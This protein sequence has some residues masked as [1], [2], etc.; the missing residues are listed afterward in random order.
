[1]PSVRQVVWISCD[2]VNSLRDVR[3]LL[4]SGFALGEVTLFDMFPGTWHMEVA[5]VCQRQTRSRTHL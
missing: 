5:M 3:P 1:M 4:A 2:V